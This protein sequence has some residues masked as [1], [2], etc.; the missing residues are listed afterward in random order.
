M[1]GQG[2]DHTVNKC[3]VHN[4][5]NGK[6]RQKDGTRVDV[7]CPEFVV[8]YNKYMDG[9]DKGDQLRQYYSVRTKSKKMYK[10]IFW[11]LFDVTIMNAFIPNHL[12][13]VPSL[14]HSNNFVPSLQGN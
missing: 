5:S 14:Y 11:F 6:W 3:T 7:Q 4:N 2:S 10:Y 12:R 9:V 13:L 8:L 1:A